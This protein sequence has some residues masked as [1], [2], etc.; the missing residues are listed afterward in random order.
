MSNFNQ[1]TFDDPRLTPTRKASMYS[2]ALWYSTDQDKPDWKHSDKMEVV[3]KISHITR[4]MERKV[5]HRFAWFSL[6]R[7]LDKS[8]ARM[9]GSKPLKHGFWTRAI[10]YENL[11]FKP[12][13]ER[14]P[15]NVKY[16]FTP[17]FNELPTGG[18]LL[19]AWKNPHTGKID[20]VPDKLV[21][22]KAQFNWGHYKK[23]WLPLEEK[24]R[25]EVAA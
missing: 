6:I 3:K 1:Y 17:Q 4:D 2:C 11:Y 20:L 5:N 19:Q 22:L 14:I 18:V 7:M 10:I 9:Q 21:K 16:Q 12:V 23:Y 15:G 25:E 24:R 13:Y 8:D